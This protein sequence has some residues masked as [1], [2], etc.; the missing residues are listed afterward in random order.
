MPRPSAVIAELADLI[1]R[2]ELEVPI[3]GV[4]ALDDVR[5]A[6]RELEL[7]HTRGKVVLRP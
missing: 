5:D 3:D 4:Y 1:A 7:R 2:G 6:Y